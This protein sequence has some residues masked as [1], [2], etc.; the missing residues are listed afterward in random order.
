[1]KAPPKDRWSIPI[2]VVVAFGWSW[3]WWLPLV[4][5]GDTVE[6]GHAWP[7][8]FPGL[9][10]PLIAAI[11]VTAWLDG[12]P[13]LADYIRRLVRWRIGAR[14]WATVVLPLLAFGAVAVVADGGVRIGDLD[15]M[16]GLPE[17]GVPLL[18]VVLIFVNGLGEEGGWRGFLFPRFRERYDL[19][20]AS[21]AVAGI[22][23]AW[24]IPLFLLLAS[25]K[26]FNP[27][28]LVGF[29]IGLGA[30]AIVLGWIYQRTG[31]SILAAAAWHGIYNLFAGT[32]DSAVRSAVVTGL[33]IAWA[34]R[35]M[36]HEAA[37]R[38]N[39]SPDP[40]QP[41]GALDARM[42]TRP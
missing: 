31:A 27:F 33:V 38:S 14:A 5:S 26:G 13:A 2:F 34:V 4:L 35:I 42:G 24:H 25:Y 36:R 30:G 17:L 29:A 20:P 11:V 37:D 8:Q 16:S 22:W 41:D 6:Q 1:V 9:L 32:G 28:T 10:G 23:A 19:V 40:D 12:R 21:L 3:A 7:S 18:L 39:A 15:D